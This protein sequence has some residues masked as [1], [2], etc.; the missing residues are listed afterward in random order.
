MGSSATLGTGSTFVGNVLAL[1]SITVT[2]GAALRGR[3]LARN[4]AVTLDTN[5][6]NLTGC[7][8]AS[9]AVPALDF[10]GLAMLMMF[11]AAAG[12]FVLRR[13]A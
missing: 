6:V 2:T 10:V 12:V 13:A 9:P 5:S 4:G 3:A 8:I 7:G 11:F 1:T